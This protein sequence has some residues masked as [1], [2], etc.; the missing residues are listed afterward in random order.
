MQKMYVTITYPPL[1]MTKAYDV[2]QA[3]VDTLIKDLYRS[4]DSWSSFRE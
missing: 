1:N 4:F 3:S 2:I